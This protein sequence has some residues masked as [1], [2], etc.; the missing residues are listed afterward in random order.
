MLNPENLSL[1]LSEYYYDECVSSYI[2]FFFLI[3]AIIIFSFTFALREI[4]Y[5]E[6]ITENN[7][8]NKKI[9]LGCS[10]MMGTLSLIF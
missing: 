2:P 6:N 3:L 9:L 5:I 7:Y 8:F 10:L 1:N 4:Q